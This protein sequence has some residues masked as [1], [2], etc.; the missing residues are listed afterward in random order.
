MVRIPAGAR[1]LPQ[2]VQPAV[3]WLPRVLCRGKWVRNVN[4]TIQLHVVPR[5]R[6]NGTIP[7]LSRMLSR[8]PLKQNGK[9]RWIVDEKGGLH[10]D[11]FLGPVRRVWNRIAGDEVSGLCP[12]TGVGVCGAELELHHWPVWQSRTHTT[13]YRHMLFITVRE[14]IPVVFSL[15]I[16]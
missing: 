10:L 6:M 9:L 2:A 3:Y 4:L 13:G 11:F 8:S 1:T 15:L 14:G 7:T 5:L 16:K 12:V